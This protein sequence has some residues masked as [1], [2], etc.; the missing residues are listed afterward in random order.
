[1]KKAKNKK[2]KAADSFSGMP[3]IVL[4]NMDGKTE[5]KKLAK[6]KYEHLKYFIKENLEV[7]IRL[8][9]VVLSVI[10]KLRF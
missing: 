3:A 2:K 7:K 8:Y 1:M 4:G 9:L 6:E 5:I 10:E